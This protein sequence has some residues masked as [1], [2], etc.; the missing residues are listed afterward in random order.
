KL[1]IGNVLGDGAFVGDVVNNGTFTFY[2]TSALDY[3]GVI[4]GTGV[5]EK[6]GNGILTLSAVQTYTGGTRISSGTLRLAASDRLVSTWAVTVS[7]TGTF[8]LNGFNQ[9]VGDLS[10][11]GGTIAIGAGTLIAGGAASTS[12]ASQVSGNGTFIKQGTG[13]LT[14]T[15]TKIFSGT[16]TVSAGK[17]QLNGN[18]SASSFTVNSGATLAG[19]GSAGATTVQN[20]GILAPG[21]SPGTFTVASLL[22]NNTSI[23]EYE[24]ASPGG[25]GDLIQVTGNLTLDGVLNVTG[26]TG[27][28]TG[29]YRLMNYGG[30]LVDNILSLGTQP[31][32]YDFAVSAG[33][34]QVNLLIQTTGSLGLQFWDG[35][36][37]TAN[38]AVDGGT[39]TWNYTTTNWATAS[40]AANGAW[41]NGTAVLSGSSGTITLGADITFQ[42]IQFVTSGYVI[43]SGGFSLLPSGVA[44]FRVDGSSGVGTINAPLGG[45]GAVVKSGPGRL[46][47]NAVSTYLGGTTLQSGLLVAG[48]VTQTGGAGSYQWNVTA[49]GTGAIMLEGGTLGF[50]PTLGDPINGAAVNSYHLA[51]NFTASASFGLAFATSASRAPEIYYLDG[52]LALGADDRT[53]RFGHPD[54]VSAPVT[55]VHLSGII[56]GGGGLTLE[57]D[58][59]ATGTHVVT[60]E[61]AAAN[62]YAGMTTVKSGIILELGKAAANGAIPDDLLVESGGQVLSLVSEQIAD[63]AG[64]TL[65]GGAL[66]PA[67]LLMDETIG[68][69]NGNGALQLDGFLS[70]SGGEFSGGL[71]DSATSPGNL[72]KT[73]SAALILSGAS[74]YTGGTEV[75][76]GTLKVLNTS[77]SATGSGP[78]TVRS[79]ATLT[80]S[81]AVAGPVTVDSG[82]NHTPG[83]GPGITAVGSLILNASSNLNFELGGLV[84]D[85][86]LV[87][88]VA[89]QLV[90]DGVLNFPFQRG[91]GSGVYRLIDYPTAG[92]FSFLNN[93][94]ATGAVPSGFSYEVNTA[95]AGQVNLLVDPGTLR[96]WDGPGSA[97]DCVVQGGAGLW[98][99]TSASWTNAGGTANTVW[100]QNNAVSNPRVAIFGGTAG[101][102]TLQQEIFFDG[103]QF[104]TDGYVIEPGGFVLHGG[105]DGNTSIRTE[106]GVT[107]TIHAPL[108]IETDLG[109]YGAGTLVLTGGAAS[110]GD[111]YVEGGTLEVQGGVVSSDFGGV[112]VGGTG[113]QATTSGVLRL[114]AGASLD[115]QQVKVWSG[116]RLEGAGQI[117]SSV[118]VTNAATIAPRG[119][120]A[121]GALELNETTVLDYALGAPGDSANSHL[122][123]DGA[124]VLNGLL[125]ITDN[126]GFTTASYRLID[127]SGL[128]TN[129]GLTL[130]SVPVGFNA[131]DFS[132]DAATTGQ[133]NLVVGGSNGPTGPGSQYWDGSFP[134][135]NSRIDG[136]S[137]IWSLVGTNWTNFAGNV[138][139]QWGGVT[140]IFTARSGTVLLTDDI[141]FRKLIFEV[142]GYRIE[143]GGQVL[144]P[145]GDAGIEVAGGATT[146]ILAPLVGSGTLT[147][148]G[149]GTLI[150]A[151]S[152]PSAVAAT[153]VEQGRLSVNTVLRS[154]FVNV[155]NAGILGGSGLIIGNVSNDGIV[156]PG[157]SIGTLAI[158][159]NFRQSRQGTLEIEVGS[160]SHFDQLVVS[161]TARLGGTLK[162]AGKGHEFEYGDLYPFLHAGRITGRFSRII[163]PDPS[164][165]R[166]RFFAEG[167]TGILLIAPASY[168][169]VAQT[170]NQTRLAKALDRWIGTETGDT[171]VATLA[172]DLLREEQY[173]AA[174]EAILP[175]YYDAALRTGIELSHNHGQLLHQQLSARRL[176]QR[177]IAG[178]AAES[179]DSKNPKAV[180]KTAPPVDHD[181]R[182]QSWMLGSGLFSSG[183]L[184]LTPGEDFE[185]GTFIVGADYALSEHLALGV[186]ASYQEGWGDYA[187]GGET[188]LE[189]V[190][191]G[192]YATVDLEGFYANAAMG[193]GTTDYSISRPLT[194]ATLDR[195]ARSSPGAAEFFSLVGAGYDF[196]WGNFTLGPQFSA[197]FTRVKLNSVKETGAGVLS[198]GIDD[199]SSDSLRTYLGGR[200]AYT[201]RVSERLTIIPELRIFWQHELLQQGDPLRAS[202][203]GGAGPTFDFHRR[204]E[205][206][207]GVFVG[208]GVGFQIGSQLYLNLY[209]NADFGRGDDGNHS[210]SVSANYKF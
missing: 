48:G 118:T 189:S 185:S 78:V 133:V 199:A 65:N 164:R 197:Q 184:S 144:M 158:R 163:V 203:D 129:G 160:L 136:G 100:D 207:D 137:G 99:T 165:L 146:G 87:T 51:N 14:I 50:S 200:I 153:L 75:I 94:L 116:S 39:G 195:T 139:G 138:N 43:E 201:A 180:Q 173:P 66:T 36:N 187:N 106:A 104:L 35:A 125:N 23:L 90:L 148:S 155:G 33:A 54:L 88:D 135:A 30:T 64:V 10:S 93:V 210:V 115:T 178:E 159:G 47:L 112:F 6:M 3:A 110:D 27:F 22:L 152:Q 147:K 191:F 124:L 95:V 57:S 130:Q 2:R 120:L 169:L 44:T 121:T 109:K 89:G 208:A 84:N 111:Y 82:G 150:L 204:S 26:L 59:L 71:Q 192:L 126:G 45:S 83:D 42:G 68:T 98:N 196:Q 188:N 52:N 74:A 190:R 161:G 73:S 1:Q 119:S 79:G 132:I 97:N 141:P 154:P 62:S 170:P 156:A 183:G 122:Q 80:G 186:F 107:A 60:F 91:F 108:V 12:I 145:V 175:S 63:D 41:V 58:P 13:T 77:G 113:A 143:S 149:A 32:G 142:N 102:V 96:F 19:T 182:W 17:L 76:G 157:N 131:G 15:G 105:M 176:G 205:E 7:G 194:W 21:S 81:G 34:G 11:T 28:T 56:S 177:S 38:N 4:S 31:S 46:V 117:L 40:G 18:M 70:L 134:L 123:V 53:I 8:S 114:A 198:L 166:G 72:I 24:L 20:G 55:R 181:Q 25:V 140:A 128:L 174:F 179:V 37:T 9:T 171:G 202:L 209:Y 69:L 206:R 86:I 162:V 5:L 168:T 85:R 193:G 92:T 16:T 49:L 172:L 29:I 61:G 67:S 167:G 127:Y 151:A 103:L 101:T